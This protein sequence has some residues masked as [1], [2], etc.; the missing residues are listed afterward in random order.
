MVVV[1]DLG[2]G[3]RRDN[4]HRE[5]V[6]SRV[7]PIGHLEDGSCTPACSPSASARGTCGRDRQ[8]AASARSSGES[9]RSDVSSSSLTLSTYSCS[10]FVHHAL[11]RA[12]RSS[13][14]DPRVRRMSTKRVDAPR[15][16]PRT[17]ASPPSIDKRRRVERRA[18]AGGHLQQR[19]LRYFPARRVQRARVVQAR[20]VALGSR[21][22]VRS[23]RAARFQKPPQARREARR[24][25]NRNRTSRV[26]AA[27]TR[28]RLPRAPSLRERLRLSVPSS[29]PLF[30]ATTRSLKCSC[31]ASSTRRRN[32][33]RRPSLAVLSS[34]P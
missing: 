8:G 10:T 25:A 16:C 5:Q 12:P 17:F 1:E 34:T 3:R 6:H 13:R 32:A 18:L 15:S 14:R 33:T 2:L 9:Q 31:S 27:L 22:R 30:S 26:H 24:R 21:T 19:E 20:L 23:V 7:R 29:S 4:G 28:T 11:E